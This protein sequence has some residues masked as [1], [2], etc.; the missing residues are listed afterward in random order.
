MKLYT[1]EINWKVIEQ[2]RANSYYEAIN[3]A[4]DKRI[5]KEF[6]NWENNSFYSEEIES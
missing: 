3:K 1:F 5:T 2:V 6:N 4:T